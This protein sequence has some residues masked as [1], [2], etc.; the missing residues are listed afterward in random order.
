VRESEKK[1][2]I[3]QETRKKDKETK[4]EVKK[5]TDKAQGCT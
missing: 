4:E 1:K 3:T 2:E 5:K